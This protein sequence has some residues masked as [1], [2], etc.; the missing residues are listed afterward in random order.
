M[1]IYVCVILEND[2]LSSNSKREFG[3]LKDTTAHI[4]EKP[5]EFPNVW[6]QCNYN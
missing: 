5:T 3:I 6:F 1:C 4:H 2:V